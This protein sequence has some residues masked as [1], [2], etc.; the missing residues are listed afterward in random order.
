MLAPRRGAPET[1]EEA[2]A[3]TTQEAA[4]ADRQLQVSPAPGELE[5]VRAFVNTLD[6]E[7]A[8]DALATPGGLS[9]WLAERGLA[10]PARVSAGD[11]AQAVALREALRGVLRQR[12]GHPGG[13]ARRPG[14][15][16][17]AE[18]PAAAIAGI[19]AALP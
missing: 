9:R 4:A 10:A 11:L 2:A 6:I 14:A 12:A 1:A 8:T 15:E 7:E 19:A 17:T 13:S 18:R 16:R 5:T 3:M